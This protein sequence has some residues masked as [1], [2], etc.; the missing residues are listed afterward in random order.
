MQ[1]ICKDCG[2][3]FDEDELIDYVERGECW[4]GEFT[5]HIKI[6]PCCKG[7]VRE[8]TL[9]CSC[10]DEY[11]TGEYITTEDGRNYCNNCYVQERND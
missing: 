6:C 3:G 7:F 9:K 10:C 5:E 1:Y 2:R 4:G 8:N 11:I